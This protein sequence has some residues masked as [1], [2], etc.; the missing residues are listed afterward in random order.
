MQPC[1]LTGVQT[2]GTGNAQRQALHIVRRDT[3]SLLSVSLVA[4]R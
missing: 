2:S 3:D 4:A 1:A